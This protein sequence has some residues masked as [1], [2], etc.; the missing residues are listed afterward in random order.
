MTSQ[1]QFSIHQLILS[2]FSTQTSLISKLIILHKLVKCSHSSPIPRYSFLKF[3]PQCLNESNVNP[4]STWRF[5][6]PKYLRKHTIY[7]MLIA[8]ILSEGWLGILWM[9][10]YGQEDGTDKL[11][12]IYHNLLQ[13]TCSLRHNLHVPFTITSSYFFHHHLSSSCSF[14]QHLL[15]VPFTRIFYM[16]LTP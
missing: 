10:L 11:Y 3:Q 13:S 15:H 14:H 8:G 6:C 9:E 12:L 5:L 16:F 4:I 7:Q 2:S 1:L